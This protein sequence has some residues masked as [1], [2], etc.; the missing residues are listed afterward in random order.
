MTTQIQERI[1]E[2]I[3]SGNI[4]EASARVEVGAGGT[5]SFVVKSPSATD[6]KTSVL[7]FTISNTA[8]FTLDFYE[9]VNIDTNGTDM[10]VTNSKTSEPSS[11]NQV[12]E[13]GGSYSDGTKTGE[14]LFAAGTKNQSSGAKTND[15]R[16]VV[17]NDDAVRYEF[18]NQDGSKS[19]FIGIKIIF[20][21]K[22]ES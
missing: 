13:Y 1:V 16:R 6:E 11:T 7:A 21:E 19:Q 4:K 17:S 8:T 10:Y 12:F 14:D 22:K 20:F 5:E 2:R 3:E 15:I 18:T 9:N